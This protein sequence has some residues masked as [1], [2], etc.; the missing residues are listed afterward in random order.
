MRSSNLKRKTR[1]A[2]GSEG[3][4]MNGMEIKTGMEIVKRHLFCRD[5][6]HAEPLD[7]Y[8]VRGSKWYS[9]GG[10]SI[11]T[12]DSRFISDYPLHVFDRHE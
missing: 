10:N 2:T 9:F 5:I 4:N 11:D 7:G 8:G 3:G 6:Y 12:S 1:P